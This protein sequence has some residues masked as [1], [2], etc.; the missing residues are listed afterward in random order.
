MVDQL[1]DG[2]IKLRSQSDPQLQPLHRYGRQRTTSSM[3]LVTTMETQGSSRNRM[4]MIV[5]M[6]RIIQPCS[7]RARVNIKI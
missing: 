4:W 5:S 7:G 6:A 2:R 1:L 3:H